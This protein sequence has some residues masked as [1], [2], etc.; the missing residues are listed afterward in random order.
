MS[1]TDPI[2][3]WGEGRLNWPEH[4][5]PTEKY[6]LLRGRIETE[7]SLRPGDIVTA[8]PATRDQLL[9]VH[10]QEYLRRIERYCEE[11]PAG[12]A[13]E[14]EA[15]CDHETWSAVQMAVGGSVLAAE[16]ALRTG[17]A[18]NL[19]GG[20]HHAFADRGEGFC[21][22]ND[23]AVAARAVQR[24]GLAARIAVVDVDVHQGNGT[25][26]IFQGDDSVFTYSIHQQENYPL[27]ERGDLDQGLRDGAGDDEYNEKL[28]SGMDHILG[29]VRPELV[30]YVAGADAYRQDRL[31]GL[32]LSLQ[33]LARRDE[34]VVGGCRAAGV[35]VAAMLAGGYA[36]LVS[37]V[38]DIHFTLARRIFECR[39]GSHNAA[40]EAARSAG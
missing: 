16:I 31:G 11:D 8:T 23:I 35:P 17:A 40:P 36:P 33:G 21:I 34:I 32:N 1:D 7:L 25:A 26:R 9:L 6:G 5:F 14:F 39:R 18:M 12:A 3:V 22:L 20:F 24:R 30:L 37:H 2:F 19:G 29:S 28:A 10:S 13:A 27:K 38:V 4:V 15:P